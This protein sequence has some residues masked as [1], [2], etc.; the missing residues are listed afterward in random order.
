MS[1][2][3]KAKRAKAEASIIKLAIFAVGGQGGGVLSA[4]IVALAEAGGYHVQATSVAG[5][6][7]RTGATI[8]YIEMY[9]KSA[10]F[11]AP[12][13]AL[14]PSENDVDIVLAAEL[15]EAGRAALRGFIDPMRTD[16]ILS[17]HRQ[18]ATVEK[19]L[20]GNGIGDAERLLSELNARARSTIGFDMQIIAK[21]AGTVISASMFGAL[22]GAALLPFDAGAFREILKSSGRGVARNLAAFEAA[23]ERA[24]ARIAKMRLPASG[25]GAFALD[26]EEPTGPARLIRGWQE[27]EERI[28][29]LPKA[30]A[31]IAQRGGRKL[32]EFQDLDY[33][34]QYLGELESIAK[35]DESL[36]GEAHE[37][38]LT[39]EAAK[40]LANA[41][42]YDDVIRVADLKTSRERFLRAREESGAGPDDVIKIR[43]FM[44][45]GATEIIG[46]M[47]A[48][49]GA[50]VEARPRLVALIDRIVNRGRRV[51]SDRLLGFL[52]LYFVAGLRPFRRRLLRHRR[53]MEH[54]NEWLTRAKRL[55]GHD[56]RLGVEALKMRRLIKGY[57]STH[58]R[59]QS[60]YERITAALPALE[61]RRDGATMLGEL[62]ETALED[63]KGEALDEMLEA[64]APA[65]GNAQPGQAG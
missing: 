30:A 49:M 14:A 57:S 4:W 42:A 8:Y 50:W 7:Q 25:P 59:S 38:A 52:S 34:H 63:E 64:L 51:R 20:P 39:Y 15:T 62:I 53:E 17:T 9:P 43:E 28:T 16:L 35:L 23:R 27:V 5:V 1:A 12:I 65:P 29:N 56:Y 24:S 58:E 47:P 55:A 31:I 45:P 48:G 18:L 13:F 60:K 37:F 54:I 61:M 33:A 10:S 22:A 32:A 21:E 19:I 26:H 3:T 6:A 41:L 44:R 40:Y 11:T 36:G 2:A 46:M